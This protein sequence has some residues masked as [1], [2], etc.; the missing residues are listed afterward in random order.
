MQVEDALAELGGLSGVQW[1]Y[2]GCLVLLRL[3]FGM[4]WFSY[5]FMRVPVPFSQDSVFATPIKRCY[6]SFDWKIGL[7]TNSIHRT[8]T[9]GS[10]PCCRCCRANTNDDDNGNNHDKSNNIRSTKPDSTAGSWQSNSNKDHH[11]PHRREMIQR[12]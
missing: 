8:T 9:N 3:N 5:I 2:I 6:S 11:A 7:L 4:Y 12:M 10:I 1:L